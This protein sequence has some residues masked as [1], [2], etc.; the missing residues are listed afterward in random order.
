MTTSSNNDFDDFPLSPSG[1]LDAA[2]FYESFL[3]CQAL[4][5]AIPKKVFGKDFDLT[6]HNFLH[7]FHS[8][9]ANNQVL[10]RG[11]E[12]ANKALGLLWLS[13]VKKLAQLFDSLNDIPEFKGMPEGALEYLP[14]LSCNIG[15]LSSLSELLLQIGVVVIYERS[16][17]GM[18]I[19]GAA[20]RLDSGRP[21]IALSLRYPR[22]DHFWFTL[23]HELAHIDLHY[24][25]LGTPIID[26]LDDV[27]DD[28]IEKQANRRASNALISRS[29]WRSCQAKY[30]LSEE[31][32]NDFAARIGI[33]PA[34]VAG[35]LQR[36][37]NRYYIFSDIVNSVDVR[38]VLLHDE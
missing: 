37:L 17:P 35:R 34:I 32:V 16:I 38:K 4:A 22:L 28:L 30:D 12:A 36:E 6:F 25:K 7:E 5:T 10:F 33:H 9:K 13:K 3:E 18:K 31:S 26:D 15:D 23:M 27:S 14:R 11:A 24:D 8:G 20:F 29:N 21:V 19:D 2:E 1:S